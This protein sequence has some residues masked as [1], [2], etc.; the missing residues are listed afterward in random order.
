MQFKEV[1]PADAPK[2][3]ASRQEGFAVALARSAFKKL[4][5]LS[6]Q[7]QIKEI[8]RQAMMPTDS[9]T[10]SELLFRVLAELRVF[11][12][13]QPLPWIGFRGGTRAEDTEKR[14]G[15]IKQ[16]LEAFEMAGT[17][18]DL[19]AQLGYFS[20]KLAERGW[21]SLAVEADPGT[22]QASVLARDAIGLDRI[23]NQKMLIDSSSVHNLPRVDVT[24]FLSLWHHIVHAEGF[25]S[26]KKVLTEV[27][28]RT[29]DV[30]FFE[31][32]QSTESG[33][34][35]LEWRKSL[36]SMEP[37]PEKWISELLIDCGAKDVKV[38]GKFGTPHLNGVKRT[39]FAAFM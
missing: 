34:R 14:W 17:A 21:L 20:F 16:E 7:N 8:F 4:A 28:N 25:A 26:G 30:C 18:M 37:S 12:L 6:V 22:Y 33:N 31:T 2:N 19:G 23:T 3:R 35:E 15:A 39:L 38:L 13:Y 36:P 11:E 9:P 27:L 1:S 5:P 10:K 29:N 32:G 24:I